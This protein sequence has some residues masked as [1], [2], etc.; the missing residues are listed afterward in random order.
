V[1]GAAR[2]AVSTAA[3]DGH[4]MERALDEIAALGVPVEP[5]F[6]KGYTEFDETTFAEPGAARLARA[7]TARGL[8][9]QA[10]SAH[11]DLSAEGADAMLARRIAFAGLI[12]API[13]V[14]NAGPAAGR[15]AILRRLDDALPLLEGAGVVLALENPGHGKGDLIGRGEEG[16]ALVAALGS[17]LVRLNLDVGNLLTYAGGVEPGL[18]AAL[19]AAAHAHL[20]DIAEDG[21]DWRFVPLGEGSVDWRAVAGAMTRLAP[22]LPVAIEL[23]LR[24]RRPRRADPLRAANPLPIAAIRDA[25]ARSLAAW[26]RAAAG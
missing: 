4:P 17:P 1:S 16:A 25:L 19:P 15:T 12:G 5:A 21:L 9:A 11:M 3:F 8:R 14:T 13:L 18:S 6:I 24:L 7:L 26:A 22:G 20:K 10:V 23:P 2:P